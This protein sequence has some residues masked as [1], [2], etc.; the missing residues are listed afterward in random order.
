MS[1][2]QETTKDGA[3]EA[4]L[5]AALGSMPYGFSIWGEDRRLVLWNQHYEQMYRFPPGAL[6]V[7]MSLREICETSVGIGNHAGLTPEQLHA[8]YQQRLDEASDPLSAVHAQKAIL[9]RV[10][11]TSHVRSPG[12]GRI[13]THEDVTA[14]VESQWM[15]DLREKTLADQNMRFD[16]ALANMPHGLSMYDADW[17]LVICND[18]YR[19]IY[20]MPPELTRSG[21][22][23]Q[24]IIDY[25]QSIGAVP[26][27]GELDYVEQVLAATRA[28][29]T[30][31]QIYRLPDGKVVSVHQS[32]MPN[33]GFVA[34]HQD[35]TRE[36]ERM[37]ALE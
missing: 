14:E 24:K 23:F 13:V 9:G 3:V 5:R 16:T 25:R 28:D 12:I 20:D 21:T 19:E 27:E 17:R 18:R 15:A 2:E 8:I 1:T 26:V 6:R 7:G 36:I 30:R 31:L 29:G 4:V 35:I 34:M 10:I 33:G 37:E 32:P 11:K 22:P